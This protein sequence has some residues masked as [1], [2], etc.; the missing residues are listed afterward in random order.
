MYYVYPSISGVVQWDI[1]FLF[2]YA[3]K[4]KTRILNK[5]FDITQICSW[6]K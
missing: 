2:P 3:P 6:Q 1:I 5:M 4:V